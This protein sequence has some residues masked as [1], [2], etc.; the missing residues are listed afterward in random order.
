MCQTKTAFTKQ[1]HFSGERDH[2]FDK[3]PKYPYY[4]RS[5]E[6]PLTTHCWLAFFTPHLYQ[7]EGSSN[8]YSLY[9][10]KDETLREIF[11]FC[12]APGLQTAP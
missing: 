4:N 8:N 12:P 2:V 7:K 1:E 6:T 3:P 9:F 10:K 11:Q 5:E